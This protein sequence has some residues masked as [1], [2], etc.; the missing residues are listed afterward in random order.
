MLFSFIVALLFTLQPSHALESNDLASDAI[1]AGAPVG[2]TGQAWKSTV[3]LLYSGTFCSGVLISY[4]A[5]LTAAHCPVPSGEQITVQFFK[6]NDPEKVEN[7]NLEADE[8]RNVA[9]PAYRPIRN[10]QVGSNDLRLIIIKGEKTIPDGFDAASL[11]TSDNVAASDPGRP[12]IVVG[13]GL[14]N[15]RTRADRLR[16]VRGTVSGYLNDGVITVGFRYGTGV[17]GGDSGGPVFVLGRRG[18]LLL[19]GITN[20]SA[21][22][23]GRECGGPLNLSGINARVY[24]WIQ[25]EISK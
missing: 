17:C 24:S 11:Q 25:K 20:S 10:G 22:I 13:A 16:F 7:L 5:I 1:Y 3:R 6:D 18:E 4:N 23:Y 2:A 9:H 8:F 15:D 14:I 12:A 19:T 21:S